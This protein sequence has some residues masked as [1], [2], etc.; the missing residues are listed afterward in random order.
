MSK[1]ISDFISRGKTRLLV[2][3]RKHALK[4]VPQYVRDR[5][6]VYLIDNEQVEH[7]QILITVY[8]LLYTYCCILITTYLLLYTYYYILI[9]VYLLITAYCCIL[10]TV[11]LSLLGVERVFDPVLD[12]GYQGTG[13]A[14]DRFGCQLRQKTGTEKK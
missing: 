6:D 7:Y 12:R 14:P 13:S 8:L 9:T 1:Q 10:I 5:A 4:W 2:I 11:Y 3:I